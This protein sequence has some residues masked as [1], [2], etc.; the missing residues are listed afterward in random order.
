[1][2]NF[3]KNILIAEAAAAEP[4]PMRPNY[5]G[6]GPAYMVDRSSP[7]YKA[8]GSAMTNA[9]KAELNK[10]FELDMRSPG[11]RIQDM[12]SKLWTSDGTSQKSKAK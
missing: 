2:N 4:Q 5:T 1:M 9:Q 11:E 3:W 10:T 6:P 7:Q 8:P 12:W